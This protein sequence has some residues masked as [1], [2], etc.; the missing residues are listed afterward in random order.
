MTLSAEQLL[1]IAQDYWDSSK[2]FYLRQETSPRTQRLQALW[3]RELENI[4]RWWSFRDD[5]QRVL[6]EFEVKLMGST[7]DAG[8]R[9]IAYPLPIHPPLP[10]PWTLVGCVSLLAPVYAVYGVEY[11]E[12]QGRRSHFR[13]RFELDLPGM[14]QPA[15]RIARKIEEV[16]DYEPMPEELARMPVPLFVESREPPHTTLFHAL[17]TSEPASIP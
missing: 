11:D 6:P 13:A 4:D 8:F 15:H 3:S 10:R 2:D 12:E 9:F 14:A 5:I 7:A 16:L 17:F 1:T